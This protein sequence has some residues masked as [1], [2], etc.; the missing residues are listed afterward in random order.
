MC[1]INGLYSINKVRG[2][3]KKKFKQSLNLLNFR[4]PDQKGHFA[5]NNVLIGNT[6]LK[7]NDTNN[8]QNG[9]Y[10]DLSTEVK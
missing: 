2:D 4:G 3:L 5:Y 1:G 9:G 8:I 10:V 7:I 6:R